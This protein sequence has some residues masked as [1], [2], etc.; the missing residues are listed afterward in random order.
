MAVKV[1]GP[2]AHSTLAQHPTP[3]LVD[4]RKDELKYSLIPPFQHIAL[5]QYIECTCTAMFWLT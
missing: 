2:Q 3:G 5:E 1:L 4:A